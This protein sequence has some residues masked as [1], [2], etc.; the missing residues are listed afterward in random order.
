MQRMTFGGLDLSVIDPHERDTRYIYDEI[1]VSQIYYRP[2]MWIPKHPIIMD[3]GANIGLY[4]IWASR[5]YQPKTIYC[6]EASP[7]T[8]PYLEDNVS[9][10]IDPDATKICASNSAL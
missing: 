1:F 7:R 6:Y 9:R 3:V 8:F 5:R 4:C 10:L 2:E